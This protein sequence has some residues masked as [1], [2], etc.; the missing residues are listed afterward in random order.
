MTAEPFVRKLLLDILTSAQRIVDR[1]ATE[2]A[3]SF[4]SSANLD[5]QDIVARRLAIIGEP[6][7]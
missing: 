1:L 7:A 5:A 6:L 2:T 4:I 3:E